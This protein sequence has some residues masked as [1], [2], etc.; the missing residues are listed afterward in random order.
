MAVQTVTATN[1]VKGIEISESATIRVGEDP[2]S[3]Q[4]SVVPDDASDKRINWSSSDTAIAIVNEQGSV[5][6]M[7]PGEAVIRAVAADGDGSSACTDTC[8]VTVLPAFVHVTGISVDPATLALNIGYSRTVTAVILP[9]DATDKSVIWSTNNASVADVSSE[10][11][12]TAVSEGTAVI[13]ATAVDGGMAGTCT[14][15]VNR[16]PTP[17]IPVLPDDTP[18]SVQAEVRPVAAAFSKDKDAVLARFK[19]GIISPENLVINPDTEFVEVKSALA[20]QL[21]NNR[22]E[23]KPIGADMITKLP[24]FGVNVE[25]GKTAA[26][27]FKLKGSDLFAAVPADIKVLKIQGDTKSE[28]FTYASSSAAFAGGR[29]TLQTEG[30][31]LYTGAIEADAEYLL[32]LF[33]KDGSEYDLDGTENGEVVDPAVIVKAE[34]KDPPTPPVPPTPGPDDGGG[35]CNASLPLQVLFL[36]VPLAFRRKI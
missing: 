3:V 21:F 1:I 34:E 35:G 28:F 12:I 36:A 16:I 2:F 32:V 14:V 27:G 10:G 6:A 25:I 7:A 31:P 11:R 20:V 13:T 23:Y 19:E 9:G 5:T 8:T 30:N 4:A 26:V 29:Y 15:T 18:G 17:V 22:D 33:I 24:V